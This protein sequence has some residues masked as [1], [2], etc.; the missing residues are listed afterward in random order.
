MT[1]R[2]IV[3]IT[4]GDVNGVGPEVVLK[5]LAKDEVRQQQRPVIIG[6][7]RFL[8]DLARTLGLPLK[9]VENIAELD[10]EN[11][12]VGVLNQESFPDVP[13]TSAESKPDGGVIAGRAL[14][15]AVGLAL[16][17]EVDAL[18]TAPISKAAFNEAG[19]R[20]AGHT[21]FLA[22]KTNSPHALMIL[23]NKDFRVALATTHCALSK[24]SARL[25]T[26]DIKAKL[27]VLDS[28]LK[29][30]FGIHEPKLAVAALNPHAGEG[31]L[32][33][34]EESEVIRPAVIEARA[35]GLFVEGPFPADTLFARFEED[36]FDAYL[37][38]YHDQGL[39]PVK[40]RGFGKAVNYTAGLP[41]IRTSPDHGTACDIAGRGLAHSGSMEEAIKLA[42][43]LVR[44][45]KAG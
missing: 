4:V 16:S 36:H 23:M 27:Q 7:A 17:G 14:E 30:R 43:R 42:S 29:L 12:E 37:A 13:S 3:G 6:P 31:G 5:A 39:I 15:K 8:R 33:G 26:E 45:S 28:D 9:V 40:M 44:H 38:M 35:M 19:Y 34:R 24:V 21:E 41:I 11:S 22:E 18:V 25:T 20:Y 2:P 10:E 1:E 32:F